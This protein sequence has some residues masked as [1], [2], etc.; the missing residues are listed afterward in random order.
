MVSVCVLTLISTFGLKFEISGFTTVLF[1]HF[2]VKLL[3]TG[4][5]RLNQKFAHCDQ[6][7]TDCITVSVQG[8]KLCR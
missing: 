8:S 5:E 2:L 6:G 7:I 1:I 4:D 3:K